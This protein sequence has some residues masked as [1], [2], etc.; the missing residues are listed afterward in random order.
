MVVVISFSSSKK[1]KAK[2]QSASVTFAHIS[3]V[4]T[5]LETK[6]TASMGEDS[7]TGRKIIQT[8]FFCRQSP[9]NTLYTLAAAI[10]IIILIN[11]NSLTQ[12]Y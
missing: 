1:T 5:S 10:T 9:S 4:H 8:I 6:P 2:T 3:L 7:S 12:S 11:I